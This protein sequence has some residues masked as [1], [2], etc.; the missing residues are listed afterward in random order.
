[1]TGKPLQITQRQIEAL[2]KGAAK[3]GM[4]PEIRINNT[5]IRLVPNDHDS[6]PIDDDEDL[7]L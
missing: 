4:R 3:A 7:K 2:C 6:K 1:M 5:Y